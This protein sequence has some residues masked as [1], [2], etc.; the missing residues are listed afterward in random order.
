MD[1]REAARLLDRREAVALDVREPAEWQAG[2]IPAA[3]HIPMSQLAQ[4]AGELPHGTTI[5]AVCRSGNR[6]GT[7][8]KALRQAGYRAE[9]LDGGMKAWARAGLPV[10]PP[11][12]RI[13]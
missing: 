1:V 6:S 7:V 2:R 4:R 3:L 13:A 12:S 10:E 8:T 5:V 9:N 11:D